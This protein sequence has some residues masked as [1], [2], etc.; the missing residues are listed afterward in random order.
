MRGPDEARGNRLATLNIRS[1]TVGG[2][3]VALRELKQGN[4]DVGVL[5]ETKFM[6]GVYARQGAGYTVCILEAEGRHWGVI[7]VVWREEAGY[8]VEGIVNFVPKMVSFL[9]TSGLQIW[10][11]VGA[12]VP[13]NDSQD[14]HCVEHVLAMAPKR[15]DVIVLGDLNARL[16]EP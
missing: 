14:F 12:Y 3:E 13:P 15:M 7:P 6:E 2:L 9:L 11:V 10:Y 1:A 16:W 5:K 4:V 8:Q